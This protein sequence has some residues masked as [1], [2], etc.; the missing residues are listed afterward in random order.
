MYTTNR[1]R[2][3]Q[4]HGQNPTGT[5]DKAEDVVDENERYAAHQQSADSSTT[6]SDEYSESNLP[7]LV[8]SDERTDYLAHILRDAD[9]SYLIQLDRVQQVEYF[10]SER[11]QLIDEIEYLR[12]YY[13]KQDQILRHRLD[14]AENENERLMNDHRSLSK[15]L[16]LYRNLVDAPEN[17]RSTTD[18]KDYQQLKRIIEEVA[19]ENERLYAELN[20]FKT[21]DPV[22]EQVQILETANLHLKQQLNQAINENNHLKQILNVDEINYLRTKLSA[23]LEECEQLK[24]TNKRLTQQQVTFSKQVHV[25]PTPPSSLS[26]QLQLSPI[27]THSSRSGGL[28]NLSIEHSSNQMVELHEHVHRL[29]QTL[30]QRDYDLQKL[31]NQ[32]EKG[33]SSIMSSIEDLCIASSKISSPP[34]ASSTISLYKHQPSIHDL[35]NEIDQLHDRLD[36]LTNENQTLQTRLQEVD[37][38]YEEN[39]Y[40]YA[41]KSQWMEEMEHARLQQLALVQEFNVMKQRERDAR[42]TKHSD[43]SQFQIQ[44]DRLTGT[45]NELENEVIHLR[46]QMHRMKQAYEKDKQDLLDTNHH[47]KQILQATQQTQKL[48]KKSTRADK[49]NEYEERIHLL[50]E[51]NEQKEQKYKRIHDAIV[52]LQND[53]REKELIFA[54]QMDDAIQQRDTIQSQFTS[55]QTQYEQLQQRIDSTDRR[56]PGEELSLVSIDHH[57]KALQ[58]KPHDNVTELQEKYEKEIAEN[59]SQIESLRI[60]QKQMTENYDGEILKSHQTNIQLQHQINQYASQ[61]EHYRSN[62]D[63]LQAEINEKQNFIEQIQKDL[64]D[65]SALFVTINNQLSQENNMKLMKINELEQIIHD[66]QLQK[67]E[68]LKSPTTDKQSSEQRQ[69]HSDQTNYSIKRELLILRNQLITKS[70]E[71]TILQH[72]IHDE[73]LRRHSVEMKLKRL[74]QE[75][76]DLRTELYSRMEENQSLQYELIECRLTVEYYSHMSGQSPAS[77]NASV[78]TP[79]PTVLQ[80]YLKEKSDNLHCQL[81]CRAYQ[82]QIEHLKKNYEILKQKYKQRLQEEKDIHECTKMKYIDYIRNIQ[83]DL[84]ETRQLLA[85]DSE[86]KVNQETVYQQMVAERKQLLFAS[87]NNDKGRD[88]H[89]ESIAL[90]SKIN[91]LEQQIL[92]LNNRIDQTVREQSELHQDVDGIRVDIHVSSEASGSSSP[93]LPSRSTTVTYLD[94]ATRTAPITYTESIGFDDGHVY[95]VSA[96]S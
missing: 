84:Q 58:S 30:Q 43:L 17:P 75:Y 68:L 65:R 88:V 14:E 66:E 63:K 7:V 21:S 39:Q 56:I 70:D 12:S 53:Y 5:R 71:N 40:L 33:T 67:M 49:V 73:R 2:Q 45:N 64:L 15:Q 3:E 54:Q 81:T 96:T 85:K 4:Q 86:V 10:L 48:P 19:Q 41:E 95:E 52:K 83:R 23:T 90:T 69:I 87:G 35:Q 59:R 34:P 1:R 20:Y 27:S 28:E 13:E 26:N 79:S 60:A 32:I 91:S 55:L 89:H 50:T 11:Y 42:Q 44:I 92:T 16:I 80:L 22:Y 82:Q 18:S 47:Y 9:L 29:E 57:T 94:S 62:V 37:T 72:S 77:D 51:Q 46:E 74:K 6:N 38:I 78:N 24:Q 8:H 76:I 31:Q 61:L 93:V 25:Y 36:E